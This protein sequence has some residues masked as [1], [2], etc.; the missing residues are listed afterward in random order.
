ML[1]TLVNWLIF[2]SIVMRVEKVVDNYVN[3]TKKEWETFI[4]YF[5]CIFLKFLLIF[6]LPLLNINTLLIPQML[7][8]V[9][10]LLHLH[11]LLYGGFRVFLAL[12]TMS[13]SSSVKLGISFSNMFACALAF[14]YEIDFICNLWAFNFVVFIK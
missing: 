7:L 6:L 3:S 14:T 5:I 13:F 4:P 8:H 12:L 1:Y 11:F 10:S 9:C 2:V